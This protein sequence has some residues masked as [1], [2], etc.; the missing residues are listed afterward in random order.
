MGRR[1]SRRSPCS[2]LLLADFYGLRHVLSMVEADDDR[3]SPLRITICHGEELTLSH[4]LA[5]AD[6][7]QDA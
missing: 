1:W 7:D 2:R 5:A 4:R 6:M 3:S